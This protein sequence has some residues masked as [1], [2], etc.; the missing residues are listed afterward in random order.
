MKKVS[1]SALLQRVIEKLT[2]VHVPLD[3]AKIVADVLVFADAS[4]KHSHGTIRLEHYVNRITL[5]GIHL[6]SMFSV[7]KGKYPWAQCLDANGGLGHVACVK[8]A[9]CAI[10]IA[11]KQ[12]IALVSIKN[13][14]HCG[15]LSYYARRIAQHDMMGV[16][17]CNTDTC[18]VPHNGK[19]PYFGTNP[20]AWSFPC[21]NEEPIVVDMSTSESSL[22]NVFVA[23]EKGKNIPSNWA[24]DENGEHTEDPNKV[25]A[26][27]PMAGK[28]GYSLA[29]II[30]T[31]T[32]I[33]TKSPF[34]PNLVPMYSQLHRKRDLSA[35]LLA[36][37]TGVHNS[38]DDF[39]EGIF[40]MAEDLRLQEAVDGDSYV[41]IPGD[42]SKE[43]RRKSE[44][45]GIMILPKVYA[46]LGFE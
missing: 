20:I 2:E 41:K 31:L 42:I 37:D 9:D 28:K 26:L 32:S 21:A 19:T 12:G 40:R 16:V 6:Q 18:V 4:E 5:G 13:T 8:A 39:K 45:E 30:E 22:G 27:L 25:K 38:M 3:Q 17:M 23:R 44:K 1:Y 46:Y 34:G 7:D 43:K 36:L 29:F 35:F 10:K 15:V 24:V 33:L 14:S 11:K